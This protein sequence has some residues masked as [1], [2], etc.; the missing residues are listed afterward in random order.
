VTT[1]APGSVAQSTSPDRIA[2]RPPPGFMT[3]SMLEIL[4]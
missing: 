4:R 1:P 2:A 3:L